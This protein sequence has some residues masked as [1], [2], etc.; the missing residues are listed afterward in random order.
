M[1]RRSRARSCAG[2]VLGGGRLCCS[3]KARAGLRIGLRVGRPWFETTTINER[4]GRVDQGE[5]YEAGMEDKE[6]RRQGDKATGAR[7]E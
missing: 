2:C 7:N 3:A 4:D 5:C 1:R 6:T